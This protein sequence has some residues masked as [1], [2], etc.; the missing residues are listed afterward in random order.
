MG[1]SGPALWG[2]GSSVASLV[3]G[4]IDALL[5]AIFPGVV[6]ENGNLRGADNCA[7]HAERKV[8]RKATDAGY[9]ILCTGASRAICMQCQQ[10]IRGNAPAAILA[11]IGFGDKCP[12]LP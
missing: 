9:I 10:A 8:V 3:Y 4:A 11:P 2:E 6:T 5:Q 1:I 7:N 12:A